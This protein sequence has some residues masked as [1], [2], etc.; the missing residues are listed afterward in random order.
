MESLLLQPV[1]CEEIN[2]GLVSLKNNASGWNAISS[3]FI[4]LSIQ[5]IVL[6][7]STYH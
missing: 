1:T 2:N 4:K 6:L 5:L 3:G 7:L